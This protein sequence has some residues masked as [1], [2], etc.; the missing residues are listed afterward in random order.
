[1]DIKTKI[2]AQ[3]DADKSVLWSFSFVP[4]NLQVITIPQWNTSKYNNE[5]TLALVNWLDKGSVACLASRDVE[6]SR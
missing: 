3:R 1:V 4:A 6:T 5:V 2:A